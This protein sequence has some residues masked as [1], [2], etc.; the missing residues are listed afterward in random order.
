[1]KKHLVIL[2]VLLL[3]AVYVPVYG[4]EKIVSGDIIRGVVFDSEGP[5]MMVNV[6]ERDSNNRIVA[7]CITDM[8]GS[9]SFRLVNPDHRIQITYVGYES[10]SIPI[11]TTFFEIKMEENDDL[12]AVEITTDPGYERLG[13]PVPIRDN[14]IHPAKETMSLMDPDSWYYGFL[15]R[16]APEGYVCGYVVNDP[17]GNNI[18]SL[19]LVKSTNKYELVRKRIDYSEVRP[20]KKKLARQLEKVTYKHLADAEKKKEDDIK[21]SSN[22]R[23]NGIRV[24]SFY[25]DNIIYVMNPGQIAT[26]KSGGSTNLPDQIW[27]DELRKFSLRR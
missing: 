19:F 4:Q 21:Q 12:P 18:Y 1:M 9:F 24:L 2:S 5:M 14:D 16:N 8:D 6:A 7:H 23:D 26:F 17:Q 13:L 3:Q 22:K 20:I 25:D 11:D 27:N 15:Q 10:V